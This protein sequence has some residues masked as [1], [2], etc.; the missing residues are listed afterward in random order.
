MKFTAFLFA[1][2]TAT[3]FAAAP[4]VGIVDESEVMKKYNKAL[5]IQADIRK[6]ADTSQAAVTERGKEVEQLKADLDSTVKRA[7]DPILSEAGKKS[8]MSEAQV[9]NKAFQERYSEFQQFVSSANATIQQRIAEMNKQ[10]GAD[11]RTQSEKIAKAKGLQIV[12]SKGLTVYVDGSL[13]ITEEVIKELNANYKSANPTAVTPVPA[14]AAPGTTGTTPAP[15]TPTPAP[16]P[17]PAAPA[18][19]ANK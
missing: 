16:T 5:E 3:V 11:I 14:P 7:Q 8:L 6:S 10:I 13:D 15:V 12:L 2:V 17:A 9:K 1:W 4:N 18:P 19:A